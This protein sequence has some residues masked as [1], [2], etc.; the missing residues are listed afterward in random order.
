M[1]YSFVLDDHEKRELLRIARATLK[2]WM[3]SGRM[4][5]GAPHRES[6]TDPAGVFVT[7]RRGETLRGC[8]GTV[9]EAAPLY[10]AVQEM[11]I[12][13]ATRDP[14]FEP[15]TPEEISL[16][17]I[18]V[19]VLGQRRKVR[20]PCDVAVGRH[21]VAVTTT[22]RRGLLLPQVAVEHDWNAETLL[23]RTCEKAGLPRDAWRDD[24]VDVEV[25]EAQVFDEATIP[26][27]ELPAVR[28]SSGG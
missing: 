23:E 9:A 14:R 10:R 28:D 25:F 12:A 5:P 15:I 24:N 17:T 1:P 22:N 13:A 20:E 27:V 3:V 2:E 16:L 11:A 8:I 19:S 18:E 21:G 26:A 6:L 7:L 4:P